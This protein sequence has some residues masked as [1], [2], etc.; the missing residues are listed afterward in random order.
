MGRPGLHARLVCAV[1]C[2]ATRA[3]A[4]GSAAGRAQRRSVPG[5]AWPSKRRGDRAAVGRRPVTVALAG[6]R[7]VE[8]GGYAAGPVIGKHLGN[9][10]ADVIRIE[11]HSRL[12]GFRSP[13]PPSKDNAPGPES[14]GIF[15]Y[16]NDGKRTLALNPTPERPLHLPRRPSS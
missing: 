1:R 7:V 5:G 8:L 16:F 14:A 15:N 2:G 3:A 6:L 4:H 9:Y 13:Y 11:S 10:G 12:D